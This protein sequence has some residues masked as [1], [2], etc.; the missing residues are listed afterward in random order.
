MRH[1][2][3][4]ES[5]ERFGAKRGGVFGGAKSRREISEEHEDVRVFVGEVRRAWTEETRRRG[6]TG[7]DGRIRIGDTQRAR[8]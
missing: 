7:R 8:I 1:V 3:R 5:D 4:I 2:V 6:G